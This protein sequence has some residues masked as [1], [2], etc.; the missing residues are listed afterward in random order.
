MKARILKD[1]ISKGKKYEKGNIIE[2]SEFIL[3]E[4]R[5][6]GLVEELKPIAEG[7]S[8]NRKC[9]VCGS[10]SWKRAKPKGSTLI[11]CLHCNHSELY[12]EYKRPT[13]DELKR[14]KNDR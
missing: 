9:V 10:D 4:L 11:T 6:K 8:L 14:D 3:H 12:I 13:F 2:V 1:F 5:L 7:E